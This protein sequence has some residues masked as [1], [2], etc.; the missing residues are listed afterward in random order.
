MGLREDIQTDIGA[1]FDTDLADAVRTFDYETEVGSSY[2]PA[3][4]EVTED[5]TAL[6]STRGVWDAVATTKVT[7][8][9]ISPTASDVTILQNELVAIPRTTDFLVLA[10]ERYR[11]LLVAEDPVDATWVL[12]VQKGDD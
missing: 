11:I 7:D 12:T 8:E 6:E 9:N 4:G 2:D 1:A 5:P 3:T 10:G